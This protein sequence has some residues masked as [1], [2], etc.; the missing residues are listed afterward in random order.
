M[1]TTTALRAQRANIWEQMKAL[2]TK[3]ESEDRDFTAEEKS[4]YEKMEADLDSIGARVERLEKESSLEAKLDKIVDM[5]GGVIDAQPADKS[6]DDEYSEAFNEFMKVGISD[7][8]TENRKLMAAR[9]QEIKNA[10]LGVGSGS[11]GGYTVPPAFRAI[12]VET[13]KAYGTMLTES[14]FIS[15]ESGVTLPWP[16]NDDTGNIGEQ[17]GE[18]TEVGYQDITFQQA[19]LDAYMFSSK[20]VKASLQFLQDSTV[21]EQWLARKLGER[22]GRI[23]S[24]KF[25]VGAGTTTPDGI[26]VSATI[27]VTGTGSLATTTG[28]SY[29][30]LVDMQESLDPAY[31]N[32]P[33]AKW[34]MHQT[35]RKA[36]RKLKDTAGKPIWEPSV[37]AGAP[38]ML[39]GRP[40]IVNMDMAT[41]AQNSLS[42]GYGDIRA[43][44]VTRN[45]TGSAML[46]RLSER[47]AELGQV[48][49]IAFDRWDGTMQDANAFKS[50]KTTATA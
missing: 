32:S 1:A 16:T 29:D 27:G 37:Q 13:M 22:I 12:M 19:Q 9:R 17:V 18:N 42:L 23:L 38:D 21:S 15:T 14:E 26:M 8:S 44:Y 49:F 33:N 40:A 3:A 47:Y 5:P 20:M 6:D 2:T 39:L 41:V 28:I 25:T 10:A 36:I 50:F 24:S 48:G 30:N 11:I 43:A 45:V 46:L 35:M 4:S 31:G 7:M 34:M